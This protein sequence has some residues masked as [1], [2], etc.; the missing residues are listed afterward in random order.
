MAI[1]VYD[2]EREGRQRGSDLDMTDKLGKQV[3]IAESMVV[4]S[5][6]YE[7]LITHLI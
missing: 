1:N 6:L 5:Q 4:V 3:Q 7:C 2:E